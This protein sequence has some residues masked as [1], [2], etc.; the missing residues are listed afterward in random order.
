MSAFGPKQTS[1]LAPHIG[2]KANIYW[3][4]PASYLPSYRGTD[5]KICLGL[6]LVVNR[7]KRATCSDVEEAEKR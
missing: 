1:H 6:S 7:R 3:I 5:A 4:M 2:G